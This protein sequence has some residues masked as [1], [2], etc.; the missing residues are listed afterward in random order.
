MEDP[1]T[2]GPEPSPT[3]TQEATASI[4]GDDHQARAVVNTASVWSRK[5][6]RSGDAFTPSDP[7]GRITTK[8]V[9]KLIGSLK[10]VIRHQ[11]AAIE[12]T[13]SELQEIKHNQHVL[14]EQNEK[15]HE[16]VKALRAQVESTPAATA[17]RT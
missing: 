3:N 7:A 12:S 17:T 8:E 14:Q 5:R 2:G 6:T 11:T 4:A 15:L 10:D 13:Q 1:P 16:E 9:W